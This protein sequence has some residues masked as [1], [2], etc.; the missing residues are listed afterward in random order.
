LLPAMLDAALSSFPNPP[1]GP[2]RVNVQIP[3]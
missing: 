3:R 1:Q 2:R